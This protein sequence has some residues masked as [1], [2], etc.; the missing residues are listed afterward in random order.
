MTTLEKLKHSVDQLERTKKELSRLVMYLE[1]N[2]VMNDDPDFSLCCPESIDTITYQVWGLRHATIELSK[3][4]IT[5]G[6]VDVRAITGLDDLDAALETLGVC[7]IDSVREQW[8]QEKIEELTQVL[9]GYVHSTMRLVKERFDVTDAQCF[10]IASVDP[11]VEVDAG[12]KS[13]FK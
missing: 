12:F 1:K 8:V 9:S 11:V 2:G 10:E 13:I 4:P 7:E 3:G 5:F 6:D